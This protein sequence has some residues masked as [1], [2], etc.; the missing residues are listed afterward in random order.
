MSL[1]HL[2]VHSIVV[3]RSKRAGR[4][5]LTELAKK[6]GAPEGRDQHFDAN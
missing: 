1:T 6:V 3:S 5:H 4:G 2:I